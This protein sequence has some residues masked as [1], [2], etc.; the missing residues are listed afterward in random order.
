VQHALYAPHVGQP[1]EEGPED[2]DR[3]LAG[4]G[5]G[6]P[7]LPDPDTC[8]RGD[9]TPGPKC[10]ADWMRPLALEVAGAEEVSRWRVSFSQL[11]RSELVEHHSYTGVV[12][13]DHGRGRMHAVAGLKSTVGTTGQD[14]MGN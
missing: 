12:D 7:Q 1:Y 2:M 6:P 13:D 5:A 8:N 11:Y 9:S 14:E 3:S 10:A 4:I